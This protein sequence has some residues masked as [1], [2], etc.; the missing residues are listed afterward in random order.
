MPMKKYFSVAVLSAVISVFVYARALPQKRSPGLQPF[1][2]TRIDWLVTY[3]QA[4]L[5]EDLTEE[6][7]FNLNISSSDPETVV[8]YVRYFPTVD[9]KIMNAD[10]DTARKVI[11]VVAQTYG[12][13]GWVKIKEDVELAEPMK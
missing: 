12:W 1:T 9:R 13:D 11:H 8:I 5:R 2:P 4:S 10:I 7:N 6:K 3:L